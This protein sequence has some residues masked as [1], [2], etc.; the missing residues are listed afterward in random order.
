MDL[1][2]L[3]ALGASTAITIAAFVVGVAMLAYGLDRLSI[4]L[5]REELYRYH[6]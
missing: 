5:L 2:T 6:Q 4:S 3:G 1:R